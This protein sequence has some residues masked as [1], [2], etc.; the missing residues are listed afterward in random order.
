M[1]LATRSM[2]CR[3]KCVG[4]CLGFHRRDLID[5]EGKMIAVHSDSMILVLPD[6]RRNYESHERFT[7]RRSRNVTGWPR[8]SFTP[9]FQCYWNRARRTLSDR[10][11]PNEAAR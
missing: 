7:G 6:D 8:P 3:V 11:G 4:Q 5:P 1:I 10:N 9:G 2:P